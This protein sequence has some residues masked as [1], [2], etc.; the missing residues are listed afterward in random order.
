MF[1]AL[2]TYQEQIKS[3]TTANE[4]KNTKHHYSKAQNN[5]LKT[6]QETQ[7]H[8][9]STPFKLSCGGVSWFSLF[10]GTKNSSKAKTTTKTKNISKLY[11]TVANKMLTKTPKDAQDHPKSTPCERT[12][13]LRTHRKHTTRTE[14]QITKQRYKFALKRMLKESLQPDELPSL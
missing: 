1:F 11:Y 2:Q 5:T 3:K 12:S 6:S 7:K 14:Q 13:V 10:K 8:P 4:G 9:K